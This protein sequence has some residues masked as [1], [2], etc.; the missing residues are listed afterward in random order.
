MQI[1]QS[2]VSHEME[3]EQIHAC[4]VSFLIIY[5]EMLQVEA[6]IDRVVFFCNH[7]LEH[8]EKTG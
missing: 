8:D 4:C 3:T 5:C 2:I 7:C 1:I 6:G